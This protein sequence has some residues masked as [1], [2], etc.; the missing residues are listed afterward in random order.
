[1]DDVL[2]IRQV[3]T[4]TKLFTYNQ[5]L[6]LL[7]CKQM[8][9]VC[10][11]FLENIRLIA[12]RLGNLEGNLIILSKNKG[13]FVPLNLLTYDLAYSLNNVIKAMECLEMLP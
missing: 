10:V 5:Y 7:I 11:F 2:N 6:T 4:N 8:V 9:S 13:S 12:N 1:M 3:D